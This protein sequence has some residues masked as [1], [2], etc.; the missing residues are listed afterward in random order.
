MVRRVL[1]AGE[2]MQDSYVERRPPAWAADVVA[3]TWVQRVGSAPY[4]QR[5]LPSGGVELRC[6]VGGL[7][8]VAGP[9]TG[10]EVEVLEPG[11]VVVGLRLRPA[12]AARAL[13]LPASETT[14]RL[15]GGD[16]LWGGAALALAEAV[17]GAADA[18]A[19]L[20]RL[21]GHLARVLDPEPVDPLVSA[22][23][24]ALRWRSDDV[25]LLTRTLHISER[26]LRRRVEA[27]VGLSPKALHR[28]LRFQEFLA[29]GQHAIAHGRAPTEEGLARLAAEAGYAD[30]A[31]MNRECMRL[32]GLTP[33]ALLGRAQEVCACGHDH[34]A[35]FA[36]VLGSRPHA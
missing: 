17:D 22:A 3:S 5:N 14:N 34:A 12:A 25:G 27:A 9:L 11:T 36:P 7:P 29:L 31:H 33:G 8:V 1:T 26:Q 20:D 24:A 13:P 23:V 28:T 32:T 2:G 35:A 6:R 16:E 15:V 18:D 10:P 4:V 21:L 19:A 30:Q